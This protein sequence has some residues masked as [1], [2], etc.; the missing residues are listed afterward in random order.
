MSTD[1]LW[2]GGLLWSNQLFLTRSIVARN[3]MRLQKVAAGRMAAM[4]TGEIAEEIDD[5]QERRFVVGT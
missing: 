4:M 2:S 3:N 1:G 5:D